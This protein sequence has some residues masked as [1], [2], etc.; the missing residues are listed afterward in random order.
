M[1]EIVKYDSTYKPL[2]DDFIKRSK[3]G[4]FLFYRDYME[5]HSNRFIDSSLLF[6]K[7]G[8]LI[9]KKDAL[10]AVMPANLEG[11]VIYSHNGLTFGGIITDQNMKLVR[12]L[13]LFEEL[14]VYAKAH[15]I[16]KLI[17]KAIPHIYHK[18][19][20]EEDLYALFRFNARLTKRDASTTIYLKNR[21]PFTKDARKRIR[22][23]KKRY[24]LVVA[25][26][27]DFTKIMEVMKEMVQSKYGVTPTHTGEELSLLAS[28]F[29][30][31]IKLVA[32]YQN[33]EMLA[34]LVTY[35]TQNVVHAQY[36]GSSQ[37]G[38]KIGAPE[39]LIDCVVNEYSSNKN[40]FDFGISTEQNGR[41][42]NTGLTVFKEKFGGRTIMY[43]FYELDVV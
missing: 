43:D 20:A 24:G 14:T 31:N 12:M 17:Y 16:T 30:D 23:T 9:S 15:G 28:R 4:T 18:I 10:F 42:I 13:Q 7:K 38:Q 41:Y 8:A 25:K 19:P 29:P 6:F 27:Y 5:Y 33:D 32:A 34:G 26:S 40:Y 39:V 37:R 1:I 21:V 3:N 22:Q 11:D 2:W 35:E 36:L